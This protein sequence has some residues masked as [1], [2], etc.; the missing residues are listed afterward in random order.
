MNVVACCWLVTW[1]NNE[2]KIHCVTVDAKMLRGSENFVFYRGTLSRLF[3]DAL[4]SV[5][6]QFKCVAYSD[7]P[8]TKWRELLLGCGVGTV[9]A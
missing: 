9:A 4:N 3:K 8:Y 1:L 6:N 5:L 7:G 2:E